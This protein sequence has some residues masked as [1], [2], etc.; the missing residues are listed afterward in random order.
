[1]GVSRRVADLGVVLVCAVLGAGGVSAQAT[2]FCPN[3]AVRLESNLNDE[4]FPFSTRLPDCRAYELVSPPYKDGSPIIQVFR[5]SE[6]GSRLL[7]F[8]LGGFAETEDNPVNGLSG[9]VYEFTRGG[10]GWVASG[11]AANPERFPRQEEKVG[12]E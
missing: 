1:M 7:G 11:I 2:E 3:E 12:G 8:S 9:N 5:V 4:G 10:S 6:D